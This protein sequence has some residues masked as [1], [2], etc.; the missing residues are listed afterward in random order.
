MGIDLRTRDKA[1]QGC[2]RKEAGNKSNLALLEF[3]PGMTLEDVL[4]E[5]KESS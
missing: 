2:W 3:C 1:R 5:F 4:L